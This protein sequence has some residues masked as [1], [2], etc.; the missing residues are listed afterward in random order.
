MKLLSRLAAVLLVALAGQHAVFSQG[1][2]GNSPSE[3]DTRFDRIIERWI[4][5]NET[6]RDV[7]VREVSR[8]GLDPK[9]NDDFEQWYQRLGGD[10]QG[11]DRTRIQRRNVTE[12]FDRMA[13]RLKFYGPTLTR[14]QFVSYARQFWRKEKSPTWREVRGFETTNE[15]ERLFKHLDRDRDGYLNLS[16]MAPALRADLKRWDKDKDGWIS[17]DEYL[18]YFVDRLKKIYTDW[19]AR[20][21]R[22]LPP[23]E[24]ADVVDEDRPAVI[25]PARLP[26]GLPAWFA[27]LDTD[28]DGQVAL[29]EWRVAGWSLEEFAKVDLNNDGFLEPG[30]IL[31]LLA[32]TDRDGARPHAYLLQKRVGAA[33]K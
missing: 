26:S 8:A 30:E 2:K 3:E 11:W 32:I 10:D 13:W 31:R 5:L 20:S 14:D 29:Y 28:Q 22:T 23:L 6:E 15:A 16:E 12:I 21:Q 1:S 24:V 7:V 25:R 4:E 27:P 17:P 33:S 18:A 9:G 19:Q